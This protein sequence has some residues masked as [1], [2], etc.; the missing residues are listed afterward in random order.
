[1]RSID[2][3]SVQ[4]VWIGVFDWRFE[5]QTVWLTFLPAKKRTV[6]NHVTV[7]IKILKILNHKVGNVITMIVDTFWSTEIN[8]CPIPTHEGS[9]PASDTVLVHLQGSQVESG[10]KKPVWV[11][12]LVTR[13]RVRTLVSELSQRSL[14]TKTTP[15]TT[16]EGVISTRNGRVTSGMSPIWT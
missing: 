8:F 12:S 9:I 4:T 14:G 1:M 6:Y 10:V 13:D 5:W 7:I 15:N 2:W 11:K 3:K 16:L